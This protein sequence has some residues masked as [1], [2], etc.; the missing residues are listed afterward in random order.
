MLRSILGLTRPRRGAIRF[1]GRDVTRSADPRDRARRHRLGARRP[2]AVPDAHG[3]AQPRHRA[4]AHALPQPGPI[5]E[6]CE[7][8]SPLE[9]LM[10]REGENLSGGEM[11]MVAIARALVGAPGLD[12]VRRAEPGTGAEDRRRRAGDDPPAAGGRH[13]LARG[14][15]ERRDRAC[16]SPTMPPC[17]DR[18]RIAWTGEAAALARRPRA[19]AKPAGS[20]LMA[21]PLLALDRVRKVYTRGRVVPPPDFHARRRSRDRPAR[22]SSASSARTAPARPRCSR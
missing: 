2:A 14:R 13:R 17:I 11:Q 3:G 21:A 16:R 12:P 20:A 6:A 22:R 4:E 5:K 9:Y 7:I 15:A 8:F 19:R 18:G 10:E 1:D